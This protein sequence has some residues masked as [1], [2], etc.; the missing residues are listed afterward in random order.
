MK[1]RVRF[2]DYDDAA[3][4]NYDN[5]DGDDNKDGYEDNSKI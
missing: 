2:D 3:N 4:D 5:K 1:M